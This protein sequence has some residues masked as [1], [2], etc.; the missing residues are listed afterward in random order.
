MPTMSNS[1]SS[2]PSDTM[3]IRNPYRGEGGSNVFLSKL[4]MMQI[5]PSCSTCDIR[6]VLCPLN[7]VATTLNVPL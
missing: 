2:S 3:S 1:I 5:I 7:S 4:L 6:T